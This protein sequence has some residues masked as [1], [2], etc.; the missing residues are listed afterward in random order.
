MLLIFYISHS[1]LENNQSL[2]RCFAGGAV[3]ENLPVNAGDVGSI[4]GSARSTG[5][6]NGNPFHYSC[7]E[8]SHE[9]QSLAGYGSCDC[10]ESDITE[11]LST[12]SHLKRISS[13]TVFSIQLVW[14]N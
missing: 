3:V 11:R 8:K 12:H 5:V 9:Q 14:Y 4:P 2:K 1:L 6:G 13:F 10:K 7:L